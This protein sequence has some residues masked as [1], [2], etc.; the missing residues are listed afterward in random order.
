MIGQIMPKGFGKSVDN[1]LVLRSIFATVRL[2]KTPPSIPHVAIM[3]G[4]SI[5]WGREIIRGILSYANEV[6]PWHTWINPDQPELLNKMPKG[7]HPNGIIAR[8]STPE[9][10][11]ELT[12]AG[13][14]VVNVSDSQIEGFSAPCVRTDDRASTQMAAHHFMERGLRHMAFV[15]PMHEPSPAWFGRAFKAALADH[16][17]S[18]AIFPMPPDDS[19][20]PAALTAW[21]HSLPKPVGILTWGHG[22]GRLVLELCL[23]NNIPVPHDVAVLSGSYDSLFCHSSFPALS[24]IVNPAEQIGRHAAE[25]LHRMM[26]G[27]SIPPKTV[28]L[29]PLEIKEHRSSDTIAVKDPQLAQAVAYLRVHAFE[30]ITMAD[31]LKA[32]PMARSSLERRFQQEFNRSPLDEIRRLRINKARQLLAETDLPIQLIAEACGYATY[33]Y[34]TLIFKKVTGITPTQY[35][36]QSR[37]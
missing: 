22:F 28:Y 20:C 27:E 2:M 1:T 12:T 13:L 15:G 6:G 4:T 25:L 19:N 30:P 31:I 24:G 11:A 3:I 23:N 36:K 16:D 10:A 18:C 32:V 7:M 29:P 17:L 21:L 37:P 9:L 34:L 33:N 35:R 26:Q 14:P 5:D 8:V